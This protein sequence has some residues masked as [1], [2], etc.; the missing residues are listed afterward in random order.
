MAP[1]LLA[2]SEPSIVPPLTFAVT[3]MP[4]IKPP[5]DNHEFFVVGIGWVDAQDLI[6]GYHELLLPDGTLAT[7][8]SATTIAVPAGI[9]VYNLTVSDGA[10][11]FVEDGAG[12]IS[13]V[14]VHNSAAYRAGW[15]R[16]FGKKLRNGMPP[17]FDSAKGF[18]TFNDF[19]RA[20]GAAGSNKAWHHLVEQ[21][22]NSGRFAPHLL[23]NPA[24][25]V[26]LPHGKGSIHA[27][28]S[29]Y[30]SSKPAELSGLTVRQWISTKSFAE[31]FKFSVQ[32]IK[33]FGGTKY[34]PIHL[35]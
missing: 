29:G 19:K 31:Q 18:A 22:I 28:I 30:Y 17:G 25:L 20:F 14:V 24:N 33:Q 34:L 3:P 2:V 9:E 16:I 10:T 23:Q 35:Q 4:A 7:V 5:T 27:K 1:R 32:T 21:T 8:T 6:P 11:Y 26:R 13:P 12:E 15:V